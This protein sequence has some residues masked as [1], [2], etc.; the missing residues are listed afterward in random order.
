LGDK[1]QGRR[2]G[3]SVLLNRLIPIGTAGYYKPIKAPSFSLSH[4]KVL[5]KDNFTI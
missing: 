5:K 4:S 1:K 3:K 2:K